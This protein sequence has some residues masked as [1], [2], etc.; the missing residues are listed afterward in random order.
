M[1]EIGEVLD[2]TILILKTLNQGPHNITEL[3]QK[4]G[5]NRNKITRYIQALEQRKLIQKQLQ[6]GPPREVIL[7]LTPKAKCIL[8]CTNP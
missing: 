3:A 4:L 1:P 5:T 7:T 2:L 6:P 8:Q